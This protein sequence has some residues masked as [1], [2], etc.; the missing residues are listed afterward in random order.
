[1]TVSGTHHTPKLNFLL[2]PKQEWTLN[3]TH[4]HDILK[5][6][7]MP[8]MH[9]LISRRSNWTDSHCCFF[10]RGSQDAYKC[11]TFGKNSVEIGKSD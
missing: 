6:N 1:M 3:R 5:S 4:T 9:M 7:T 10:D 8:V 2:V 11:L